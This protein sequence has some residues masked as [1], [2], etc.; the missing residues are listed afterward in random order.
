MENS[1]STE[2]CN[3]TN[4][5]DLLISAACIYSANSTVIGSLVI[6]QKNSIRELLVNQTRQGPVTVQVQ[7]SGIYHV[8]IFPIYEDTGII[9]STMV[10]SGQIVVPSPTGKNIGNYDLGSVWQ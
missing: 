4:Y 7:G 6:V 9:N 8:T 10:Y 3:I 1:Y 5:L 2:D